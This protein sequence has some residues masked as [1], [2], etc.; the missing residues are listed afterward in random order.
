[1]Q[2]SAW[3]R[4][5]DTNRRSPYQGDGYCMA[6]AFYGGVYIVK[7]GPKESLVPES[8]VLVFDTLSLCFKHC[9]AFLC[10]ALMIVLAAA[11]FRGKATS[12]E[13]G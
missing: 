12:W 3:I 7:R 4:I 2:H 9:N 8:C 13:L 10:R 11:R 6:L 5:L 1:M